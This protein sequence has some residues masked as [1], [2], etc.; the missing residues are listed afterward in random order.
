[1]AAVAV[2]TSGRNHEARLFNGLAVHAGKITLN[3]IPPADA[4]G[5]I[6]VPAV[7]IAADS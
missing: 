1:M 7:T 4:V 2:G 5:L 6:R 3:A